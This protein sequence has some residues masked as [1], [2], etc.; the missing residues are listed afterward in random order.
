MKHHNSLPISTYNPWF[1]AAMLTNLYHCYPLSL[2]EYLDLFN[3]GGE[4]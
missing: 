4:L 2:R 1:F 3:E